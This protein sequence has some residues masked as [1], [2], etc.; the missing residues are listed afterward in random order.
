MKR[1]IEYGVLFLRS[2][3]RWDV[4]FWKPYI[5]NVLK[6]NLRRLGYSFCRSTRVDSR[7][8]GYAPEPNL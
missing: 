6:K 8:Q 7:I 4:D 5:R 2:I 1:V 3:E